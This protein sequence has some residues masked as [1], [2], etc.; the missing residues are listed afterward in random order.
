MRDLLVDHVDEP[1]NAMMGCA[2]GCPSR[3]MSA[4][5]GD[6]ISRGTRS[7][8]IRREAI[9][10]F[11]AT[12]G[13]EVLDEFVEQETGK[14]S[15]ALDRRPKLAEALAKAW[16]A[17]AP[18]RADDHEQALM[19]FIFYVCDCWLIFASPIFCSIIIMAI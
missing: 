8:P 3:R 10:R 16:K 11:A 17:K 19:T 13:R 1:D 12:E 2:H 18:G 4:R 15:D 5:D 7:R 9:A 14:G 6:E